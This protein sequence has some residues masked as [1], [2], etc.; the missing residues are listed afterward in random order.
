VKLEDK[1]AGHLL[2]LQTGDSRV[3]VAALAAFSILRAG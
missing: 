3:G 2:A 1:K